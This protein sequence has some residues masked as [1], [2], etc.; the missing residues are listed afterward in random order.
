MKGDQVPPT[1]NLT[2]WCGGSHID[3]ET[4]SIRPGAFMLQTKD[5]DRALSVNWLEYSQ[6]PD[7]ISQ[8]AEV[9]RVLA[10]KMKRIG[11]TSKL[12]VLNVGRAI[13][14]VKEATGAKV[15]ISVL[16][17]PVALVGQWDD[18]SHS[19]VHGLNLDDDTPAVALAEAVI[20]THPAKID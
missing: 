20:E 11:P 18:S 8:I 6:L 9:R 2:R 16:H 12:A 10:K 17:D 13:E 3:P 15:L 5:T 19:G 4:G 1:D 7:R 14:A